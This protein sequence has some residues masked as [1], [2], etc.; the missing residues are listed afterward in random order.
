ML[1]MNDGP[2][3]CLTESSRLVKHMAFD[4]EVLSVLYSK[5]QWWVGTDVMAAI[6]F[7]A[8]IRLQS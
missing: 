4:L 6:P 2:L 3:H 7:S 8:P 1:M 5:Q